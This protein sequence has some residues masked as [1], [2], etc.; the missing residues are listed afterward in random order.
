MSKKNSEKSL[1]DLTTNIS[2]LIIKLGKQFEQQDSTLFRSHGIQGITPPQLFVLRI[3][4]MEDGWP[5]K[6][7][8]SVAKVSRPTISGIIDTMEKNELVKRVPN[9]KDGRSVLVKLT[10][11]G[12]YLKKYTPPIDSNKMDYFKDFKL[13]QIKKLNQ[14]LEKLSNSIKNI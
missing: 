13:H 7:L 14:L 9:P 10:R 1:L 3:L 4:W 2:N 11:K 8:A 5:L 12:E 6:Y